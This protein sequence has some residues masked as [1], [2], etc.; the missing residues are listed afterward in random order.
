MNGQSIAMPDA[1]TSLVMEL[2]QACCD[3]IIANAAELDALDAQIGDGD[4]GTNMR[5]GAVSVL[6]EQDVIA[7]MPMN[8][9]LVAAGNAVVMS[10]GGAAGPLYGTLLIQLGRSLPGRPGRQHMGPAFAAAVYAVAR[11]G[12]SEAGCKTMLDVLCPLSEA[13]VKAVPAREIARDAAQ[14]AEATK[15]LRALRGR[16]SFL[17]ERSIGHIDPGAASAALLVEAACRVVMEFSA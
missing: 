12:R 14:W 3:S 16:A 17:G 11:R 8:E 4:H 7:A 9:A 15:T 5:R 10:V 13:M 2:V 1:S 6:A